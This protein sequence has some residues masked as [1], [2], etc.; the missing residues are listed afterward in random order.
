MSNNYGNTASH[1]RKERRTST[2]Y[3][4]LVGT[5]TVPTLLAAGSNGGTPL[6]TAPAGGYKGMLS[7]SG[8]TDIT[9]K[10]AEKYLRL[11]DWS[12]EFEA[13]NGTPVATDPST[14]Q[15]IGQSLQASGGGTLTFRPSKDATPQ[16]A[17]AI[18]T[19]QRVYCKF[20]FADSVA[21]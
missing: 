13:I 12:M 18:S 9:F 21:I 10:F 16:T 17:V 11:L 14:S 1:L 19:N 7:V 5:G 4:T 20:V 8:S 6:V 2:I 15:L 3:A